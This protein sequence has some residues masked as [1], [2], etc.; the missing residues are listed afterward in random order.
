[1]SLKIGPF[2]LLS[3][4]CHY[5]GEEGGVH[6]GTIIYFSTPAGLLIYF[7]SQRA[8]NKVIWCPHQILCISMCCIYANSENLIHL[9]TVANAII[10]LHALGLL[11]CCILYFTA[12]SYSYDFNILSPGT[13]M[14]PVLQS[15]SFKHTVQCLPNKFSYLDAFRIMW[16]MRNTLTSLLNMSVVPLQSNTKNK[17]L[18]ALSGIYKY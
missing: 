11:L 12:Y 9:F 8:C 17:L 2:H 3:L 7:L 6:S 18:L 5:L 1:M 13:A 15:H 16:S 14:C 10:H 4:N